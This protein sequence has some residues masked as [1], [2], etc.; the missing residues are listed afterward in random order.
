MDTN[1][2][3]IIVFVVLVIVLRFIVPVFRKNDA[4]SFVPGQYSLAGGA[5]CP[6]CEL[7]YS[8][9]TFSPNLLVGKLERC[10]HCGKIAVVGRASPSALEAAEAR[11]S[12]QGSEAAPAPAI[13]GFAF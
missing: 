2:I 12:E 9:K 13:R 3:L 8:R 4:G 1:T 6:R 5:V 7:P 10:P 11:L